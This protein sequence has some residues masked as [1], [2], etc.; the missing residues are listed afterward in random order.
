MELTKRKAMRKQ[1]SIGPVLERFKEEVKKITGANLKKIVLF[2]SQARDEA[3][4][5]SDIDLVL[6]FQ[7]N[8]S[9]KT[10]NRIRDVSNSL[11]LQYDTVITEFFFTQ[12]EFQRY[13]TPFLLNVKKE[14]ISI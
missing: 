5:F 3:T 12:L 11:S 10:K 6:I 8:P 4:K 2:G 14:G 7:K 13:E 1:I 9:D